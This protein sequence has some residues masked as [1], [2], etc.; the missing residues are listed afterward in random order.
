MP[1]YLVESYLPDAGSTGVA[2]LAAQ[3][4]AGFDAG[5]RCSLVLTDEDM[6]LHVF[7]GQSPE[8][9]CEAAQRAAL[10]CDRISRI[11]LISGEPMRK[12]SNP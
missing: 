9:V 10:R 1:T 4:A 2:G 12:G 3:L 7:D 5:H 6:C 11:E 8:A